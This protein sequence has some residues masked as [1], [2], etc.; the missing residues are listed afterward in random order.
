MK[1]EW[2]PDPEPI[3]TNDTKTVIVGTVAWAVALVVLLILRPA[4]QNSWWIWTC[5]AGVGLG[6]LGLWY[7]RR[8]AAR[9]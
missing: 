9:G 3:E 5:V 8:R 1:Q 6:L 4:P 7:I 2:H